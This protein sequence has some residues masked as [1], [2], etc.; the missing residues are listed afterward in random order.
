MRCIEVANLQLENID[1]RLGALHLPKGKT[2][3][4]NVLPLTILL[5]KALIDYLQHGR[6]TTDKR[7]VFVCHHAPFGYGIAK[8]TVRGIMRRAYKKAGLNITGTHILRRTL[9]TKLLHNGSSLKDITDI[10]RHRCIDTT[11]IY[12]KIDLPNLAQ[13]SLP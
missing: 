5:T 2:R 10:L 8:E 11:T 7:S 12:T 6:P 13:V 3:Q 4:E 9:A 1:W